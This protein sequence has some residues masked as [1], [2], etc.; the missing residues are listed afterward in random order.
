M[1]NMLV[2]MFAKDRIGRSQY[3]VTVLHDPANGQDRA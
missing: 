1:I 3:G 2:D